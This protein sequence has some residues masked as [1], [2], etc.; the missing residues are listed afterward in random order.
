MKFRPIIKCMKC[1]DVWEPKRERWFKRREVTNI[2]ILF[3][4]I[5]QFLYGFILAWIVRGLFP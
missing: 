5:A 3:A 4:M 2:E 1:G